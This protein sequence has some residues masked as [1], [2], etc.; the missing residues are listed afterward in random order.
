[1][2]TVDLTAEE[3]GLLLDL[4]KAEQNCYEDSEDSTDVAQYN[5]CDSVINKLHNA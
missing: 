1:M 5:L 4:A 3:L 2:Y